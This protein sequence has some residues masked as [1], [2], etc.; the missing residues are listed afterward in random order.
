MLNDLDEF[1]YFFSF[2]L[3]LFFF[4][5]FFFFFRDYVFDITTKCCNLGIVSFVCI[6]PWPLII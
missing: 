4:F 1:I 6:K 3:F 5:F 2:F